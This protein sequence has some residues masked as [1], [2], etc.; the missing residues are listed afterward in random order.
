MVG[1]SGTKNA[2]YDNLAS[3]MVRHDSLHHAG[4]FGIVS[5]LFR[6]DQSN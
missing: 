6:N 4:E 5:G 1:L 2:N 3:S